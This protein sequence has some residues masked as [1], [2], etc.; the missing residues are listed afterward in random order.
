[1]LI[2]GLL[3][4]VLCAFLVEA[5]LIPSTF[6][7]SLVRQT[8]HSL[9]APS[10]RRF[11][12]P[13]TDPMANLMEVMKAADDQYLREPKPVNNMFA[14]FTIAR[15]ARNDPVIAEY[16]NL[17]SY[18]TNFDADFAKQLRLPE[19]VDQA[20]MVR[21]DENGQKYLEVRDGLLKIRRT[22]N[23][24]D[25]NVYLYRSR[26][27]SKSMNLM[28]VFSAFLRNRH[29]SDNPVGTLA[30]ELF[31]AV[32]LSSFEAGLKVGNFPDYGL[33]VKNHVLGMTISVEEY[34]RM[35][36]LDKQKCDEFRQK[37]STL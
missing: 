5:S 3:L 35:A 32:D 13:P 36:F 9:L 6:V 14:A 31:Y 7:G 16:F 17:V 18:L 15:A 37:F 10:I 4:S 8:R 20:M 29:S 33:I 2:T 24:S 12:A 28:S 22:T 26:S 34:C 23:N 19:E 1:M 27:A 11:S 25:K 30:A 21:I